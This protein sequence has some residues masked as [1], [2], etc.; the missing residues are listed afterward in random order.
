MC[1]WPIVATAAEGTYSWQRFT[2]SIGSTRS[3][4]SCAVA[5]EAMMAA[6]ATALSSE[7]RN[8]ALLERGARAQLAPEDRDGH[9]AARGLARLEGRR[10]EAAEHEEANAGA[11][12][13][14]AL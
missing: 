11:V 6:P 3:G 9:A 4:T 5:G 8:M 10:H 12:S 14:V 13:E 1:W 7:R 2:S